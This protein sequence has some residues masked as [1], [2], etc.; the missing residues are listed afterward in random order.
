MES[1]RSLSGHGLAR[2]EA[3][4]RLGARPRPRRSRRTTRA[5]STRWP[6]PAGSMRRWSGRKARRRDRAAL[7]VRLSALRARHA[8]PERRRSSSAISGRRITDLSTGLLFW[9]LELNAI[10]D[11]VIEAALAS[12]DESRALPALVRRAAQGQALPAR[13]KARGAVLREIGDRGAG[14]EPAVRRDD[15][16]AEVRGRRRDAADRGRRCTCCRTATRRSA[17]R[18]S[19]G[20]ARRST[21]TGGCSRTSPMSW[22]RTRKSRTAGAATRTSPTAGTWPIRWSAKWSTRWRRRCAMPIRGSATA[23]TR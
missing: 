11:A 15:G 17:K 4:S 12:D 21:T 23:T 3:R 1:R 14:L 5:S 16:V 8:G 20:S 19:T 2:A 22:P 10:D 13:R 18:R 9:E 7:V 6:S